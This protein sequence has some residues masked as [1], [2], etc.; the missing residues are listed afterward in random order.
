MVYC[1]INLE[2]NVN[3][4]YKPGD[5]LKGTIELFLQQPIKI[6][7]F[8][9]V[10]LGRAKCHWTEGRDHFKGENFYLNSK[11]YL[12]GGP[13]AEAREVDKGTHRFGFSRELPSLIPGSFE[14]P[15][16]YIKY[17]I[18]A[19]LDVPS[20]INEKF[21]SPFKVVRNDN[22]NN[23]PSLSREE[24][25]W[26][27]LSCVGS[28]PLLIDLSLPQSGYIPGEEITLTV[29]I[30][31]QS[32][33]LMTRCILYLKKIIKYKSDR[34]TKKIEILLTSKES[35][36]G[37]PPKSSVELIESVI[38]P[39]GVEFSNSKYCDVI[40]ISYLLTFEVISP[41]VSGDIKITFPLTIGAIPLAIGT[42]Q[43]LRTRHS[44]PSVPR[45]ATI[46]R[47]NQNS[48]AA[49]NRYEDPPP[50]FEEAIRNCPRSS[51][52]LYYEEDFS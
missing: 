37:V 23:D 6:R 46:Q 33:Y 11:T 17:H 47:N 34:K 14:S 42:F 9:F 52:P 39:E 2:N 27:E 22:L 50:S 43:P 7:G 15:I 10:L 30:D 1:K 44:Q 35:S 51:A 4:V 40:Q 48:V 28:E 13:N 29:K 45:L 16:G 32:N 8:Y 25:K 24:T 31:N 18:E 38:V 3:A 49:A 5:R 12:F 41:S 26:F 20:D 21:L 36:K 19:F